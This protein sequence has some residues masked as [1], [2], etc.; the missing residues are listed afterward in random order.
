MGE[1]VD[2][3]SDAEIV[4]QISKAQEV[5]KRSAVE[6]KGKKNA[7]GF[8]SVSLCV[9]KKWEQLKREAGA[10]QP[11]ETKTSAG[12]EAE[13]ATEETKKEERAAEVKEEKA[14]EGAPAP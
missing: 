7:H 1:N 9:R 2:G 11:A 3:K 13:G 14:G 10:E 5:L 8:A 4:K 12:A 6:A